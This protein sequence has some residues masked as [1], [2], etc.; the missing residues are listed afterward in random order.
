MLPLCH[1]QSQHHGAGDLAGLQ[2]GACN[3]GQC[4]LSLL[5]Q[6]FTPLA[7]QGLLCRLAELPLAALGNIIRIRG[8]QHGRAVVLR[9]HMAPEVDKQE[10]LAHILRHGRE[11]PHTAAQFVHL[12]AN[13]LPLLAQALGQGLQ[14]RIHILRIIRGNGIDRLGDLPGQADR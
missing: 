14:L 3:D 9:Q 10:S 11:F 7:G 2:H 8:Q 13:R 5:Q 6:P 1:I 4:P 12:I